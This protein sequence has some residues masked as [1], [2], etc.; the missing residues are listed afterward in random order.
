MKTITELESLF[1]KGGRVLCAV[2]GGADSVCMLHIL[3]EK[4]QELEI[5]L[6]AAHY[7]HGLRGEESLRDAA[8]VENICRELGIPFVCEHGDVKSF[9]RE[10]GMSIE[11]AARELR[12][13]FLERAADKL[14]CE[15]IA[16]AHNAD[17]NAETIL[18]NLTR[19][20]GAQ[21]LRGIPARRGRI[22]RPLL[23][24]SRDEIE[25]YLTGRGIAW[26]ED[27]STALTTTAATLS[28][29]R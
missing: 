5:E 21:G 13:D 1:D 12:Y 25:A 18:F 2:S 28:A 11:E 3:H 26:V 4:R 23:G 17:D 7:E 14:G 10:K 22:V 19:G 6:F 15:R 24:M 27:S 20:S 29:I 16:T 8:F 9:A